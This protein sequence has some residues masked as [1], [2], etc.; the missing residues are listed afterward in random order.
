MKV[1]IEMFILLLICYST[2]GFFIYIYANFWFI[3]HII[4]IYFSKIFS[5][6]MAKVTMSRQINFSAPFY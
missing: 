4:P 1:G 3:S 6:T 2:I 5:L